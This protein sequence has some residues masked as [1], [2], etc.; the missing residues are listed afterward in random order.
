MNTTP[1]LTHLVAGRLRRSFILPFEGQPR[2]DSLGGGLVYSGVGV[3]IWEPGR[4][5][6]LGRVGDDFPAEWLEKISQKG[7]DRR[8][9]KVVPE[10]IDLRQFAAYPSPDVS[11]TD[12]PVA[13]FARMGLPFPKALLEY[14]D[15]EPQMDS[16]TRLTLLTL[17]LNDIPSD[18]LDASAAH[19]CP[20]DY[21]SHNLLPSILR[22]GHITTISIDPSAGYMNPTY[23]DDIPALVNGVT[24]FLASEE[25][26]QSL[27]QGRSTDLWEMAETLVH[28][29]CEVVV[30]KRG[31]RG[32]YLYDGSNGS[33]WTIP[34]YPARVADPYGAGDAFCGGFLAGYHRY[35]DALKSTLAGNISASLVIEGNGPFY[36][37]DV[38]PGLAEARMQ[39]LKEMARR[40]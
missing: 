24:A 30:I 1:L 8:G 11:Q 25:K 4:I 38:L 36:A 34:A 21:L 9:I 16:R 13:Y 7:F 28:Y 35:Y 31:P 18:Y 22:Q 12:N 40:V 32:Q 27:F 37:L 20:M 33:R 10:P 19:L 29:G 17:R 15:R 23:W 39:A 3:S 5:G 6:M 2:L 14:N 26:V